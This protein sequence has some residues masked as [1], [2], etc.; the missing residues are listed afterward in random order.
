M[1]SNTHCNDVL[2]FLCNCLWLFWIMLANN[3]FLCMCL[4]MWRVI[5]QFSILKYICAFSLCISDVTYDFVGLYSVQ[6]VAVR[7]AFVGVEACSFGGWP[8]RSFMISVSVTSVMLIPR[9]QV[10]TR[11][12]YVVTIKRRQCETISRRCTQRAKKWIAKSDLH[13]ATG[14]WNLT[15]VVQLTL[16]VK[17]LCTEM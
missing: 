9:V 13:S 7:N 14:C 3:L 17:S 2:L 10:S 6:C 16:A 4:P 15:F 1:N 11:P 8:S 5:L 12:I